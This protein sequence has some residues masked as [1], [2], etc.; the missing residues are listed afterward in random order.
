[1]SSSV[2]EGG[3]SDVGKGKQTKNQGQNYELFLDFC[4]RLFDNEIEVSVF[5]D[6]T[7]EMFGNKVCVYYFMVSDTKLSII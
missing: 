1:M 5:E 7:R 6:Q 4:E 3:T 2:S